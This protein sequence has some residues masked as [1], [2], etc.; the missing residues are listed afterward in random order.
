MNEGFLPLLL[1]PRPSPVDRQSGNANPPTLHLPGHGRQTQR[2]APKFETLQAAFDERR[3]EI[4]ANA[5]NSDPDLVVIFETVG[6]VADFASTVER[7]PGLE[8]LFGA[9]ER[10]VEPDEDFFDTG[11]TEKPLG[12]RLFLVGSNR[13]A[14]NE[15]VRLWERYSADP[16]ANM[17]AGL[18][19]WKAVFAHLKDV[20]FWGAR[21][22]IGSDIKEQW[23]ARLLDGAETLRFEI[24]SWC[25]RA[26]AKNAEAGEQI[27]RLVAELNGRVLDECLNEEIAYH[28]FLIEMPADGVRQLI[29]DAP[30]ELV[31]AEQVM[32]FR[33]RGQAL[34]WDGPAVPQ[35]A[36]I[37]VPEQA[38]AGSPVVAVLDGLPMENHPRLAGRLVVDDPDGWA[39]DYPAR[40]RVHG[41]AMASLICWGELVGERTALSRPIY[42]RPI[43]R[44]DPAS[45]NTPRSECTPDDGL[46]I[47]LVH[48]AVRRIFESEAGAPAAA[49]S[50]KVINLS[51]GD[52]HRPFDGNELSP[53]AR[54]IDWLAYKHGVLFVVSSGNVVDELTLPIPRETIGQLAAVDREALATQA[55]LAS[56]SHRMLLAPAESINALTV[57]A[58]HT[59]AAIAGHP[60]GR[61][62]LFPENGV[63]PYSCIGPGF[64]RSVKPDVLLPGGRVLYSE[65]PTSPVAETHV[66]GAWKTTAAPGHLVAA[67]P[68]GAGNAAVYS[69]GTS[70][71]AALG[72]RAA[73][74]AFEVLEALRADGAAALESRF[75]GVLI[76]ALLAHGAAWGDVKT[77]IL[78]ARPEVDQWQRQKRLVARYAG[79][80]FADVDRALTCTEQRATLLGV[81]ELRNNKALEFHVPLPIALNATTVRRR[82]TVTLA[83]LSPTNPR[84]SKYRAARLWIDVPDEG[85]N[86]S[87]VDGD[88]RQVLLG[89]LQHEI[90]ESVSAVP[91]VEGQDLVIRVNCVADAGRLW[92]PVKFAI[93][94]S[95]EVADGIALPIYQQ[96]RE[97]ISQQVGVSIPG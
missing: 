93:C 39:A 65:H 55:L 57:G 18:S 79:Y 2:L 95:L 3:I 73:A 72:T 50:V 91:I 85:L 74:Q 41:T 70:N 46:L 45:P 58:C 63:A 89:T 15:I 48:R 5:P 81:G 53:W 9:L 31:L 10:D 56:D 32:F 42:V 90:Y 34:A 88:S 11:D 23:R 67:P 49:A 94:V 54:L 77:Q 13:Q 76:K 52:S 30:P 59:D 7:T 16:Q 1:F 40:E 71:A 25:F 12:C 14:L 96:V 61:Y 75:D 51:V 43:L 44:P 33:P 28:G 78:A 82:L 38:P 83:W 80:G 22:R 35:V 37:A 60:P 6:A 68:D 8:W 97:R 62:L 24:E 26:A 19:A 17:G 47:D 27:R 29:G 84:H 64:R 36:D 86:F 4:Q 69:R 92:H 20:R 87:R 66:R 21:D